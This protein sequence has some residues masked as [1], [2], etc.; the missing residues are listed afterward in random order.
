M[1]HIMSKR[2]G[3]NQAKVHGN[4]IFNASKLAIGVSCAH[5]CIIV[6]SMCNVG[7]KSNW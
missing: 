6:G 7:T 3:S 1:D 2:L 5:R 4:T